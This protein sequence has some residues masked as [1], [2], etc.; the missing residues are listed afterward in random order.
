[1]DHNDVFILDEAD[2][3]ETD[4]IQ[5]EIDTGE[6]PPIKQS[7][8]RM[9]YAAREKVANQLHKMKK[10][11]VMQPLKSPW[12]SPVVLVK[13]KN[14]S[15]RFCVDYRRL[16]CVTKSDNF[17]L[18]RIDD[19]LYELGKARFFSTLD[20]ASGFWQIRVHGDS[21]EKT[22]FSTPFGLFEFRVI[23][24][25]LKMHQVHFNG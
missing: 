20:L 18:P 2:R 24:F 23:L 15:F 10:L 14:G 16:N 6:A 12:A 25:G 4:L 13:K 9:P 17:P 1:M 8:R 5:L 3:G 21:Q 19:L 11:N 22:A 7:F